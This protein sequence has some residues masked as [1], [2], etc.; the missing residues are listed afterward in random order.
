MF[1]ADEAA[2][3]DATVVAVVVAVVAVVD[4]SGAEEFGGGCGRTV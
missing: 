4:S 2:V 1:A 3:W